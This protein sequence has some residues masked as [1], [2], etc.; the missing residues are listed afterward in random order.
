MVKIE[1]TVRI[2]FEVEMVLEALILCFEFCKLCPNTLKQFQVQQV[3][4]LAGEI[5]VSGSE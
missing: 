2:E 3:I 1:S 4:L 5:L